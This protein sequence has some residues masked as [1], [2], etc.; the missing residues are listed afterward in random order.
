MYDVVYSN[1]AVKALQKL[2]KP[3]AAMIFGWIEK[4]LVGCS[5]PRLNGKALAGDKREYWR[6][7]VSAYRII[8]DI[9]DDLVRIEIINVAH[10]R[11]VY[12]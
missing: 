9:Q 8:A 11:E 12:D 2:D 3:I 1:R 6:Y 5:N 4:N 10:R 7:R